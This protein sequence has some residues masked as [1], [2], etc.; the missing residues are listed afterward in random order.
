MVGANT[1]FARNAICFLLI[2]VAVAQLRRKELTTN[3]PL[4]NFVE[5]FLTA[6]RYV[7]YAP[8]I[9][10]VLV[11]NILFALFISVIPALLPVVGLKELHLNASSLGLVFTCMEIGS[12]LGA[13]FIMPLARAKFASN[14]ITA[15]ANIFVAVVFGLMALIRHHEFFLVAAMLA[16]I[17]WTMAAS[18]LWVAGQRAMPSWAR[19][20]MNATV[21]MVSQGAMALGGV[22]WGSSAL[23]WGVQA[24]LLM[25]AALLLV[26][27]IL[28]GWLSIDF[29]ETLNVEPA[30][31]SGQAHRLIHQP[32]PRD[33]PV[34]ISIDVKIDRRLGPNIDESPSGGPVDPF[35]EW[36]I[37]LA[38][39][40]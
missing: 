28:L 24:T 26:S 22:I 4:E 18:E 6:I 15:L 13:V 35:A 36:S 31:V 29:T 34:I 40:R 37:C 23:M 11:R 2:I 30:L 3:L 5:S 14:S 7:R 27:L 9:Q 17:A 10:M 20:R 12:M 1:V 19:G 33:G 16:G 21:I 39:V 25:A 8:G 38:F 32:Q